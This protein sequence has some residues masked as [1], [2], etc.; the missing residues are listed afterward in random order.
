MS[1][2]SSVIVYY[3]NAHCSFE[4]LRAPPFCMAGLLFP[5]GSY[6]LG[7]EVVS[8]APSVYFYC[9]LV[10]CVVSFFPFWVPVFFGPLSICVSLPWPVLGHLDTWIYGGCVSPC[11]AS[12]SAVLSSTSWVMDGIFH[13]LG[14]FL[15]TISISLSVIQ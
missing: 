12:P 13:S 6:V 5:H 7:F 4:F 1:P 3:G 14:H 15:M 9:S 11:S 8:C 2:S 10:G